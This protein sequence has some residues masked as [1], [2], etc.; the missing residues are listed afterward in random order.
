MDLQRIKALIDLIAQSPLAEIELIEGEDRVR[1][2]K[3]PKTQSSST[4]ASHRRAPKAKRS[5]RR[6]YRQKRRSKR[7]PQ[8]PRGSFTRRCSASFI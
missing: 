4:D 5:R 1:L 2:V 7:F 6:A 8:A 3:T